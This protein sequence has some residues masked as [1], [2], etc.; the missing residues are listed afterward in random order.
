MT[1]SGSAYQPPTNGLPATAVGWSG[2][3]AADAEVARRPTA[4]TVVASQVAVLPGRSRIADPPLRPCRVLITRHEQT[5]ADIDRHVRQS[6][7]I[8]DDDSP[9]LH[10]DRPGLGEP[11]QSTVHGDPADPEQPRQLLLRA[12]PGDRPRRVLLAQPGRE[13]GHRR[14]RG[15]LREPP[16][17]G[18]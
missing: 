3:A 6:F 1:V 9:A 8:R 4:A 14:Q 10:P 5:L 17:T 12:A 16:A 13:P 18:Q 15:R 7:P 11:G 2:M